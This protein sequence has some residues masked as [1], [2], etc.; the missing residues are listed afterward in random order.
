MN[1]L[2]Q[3]ETVGQA[4]WLDYLKR[5]LITNGE[6]KTLIERDG[7][8]GMTS[9]P[10][11][12]EKAI[13]ESDEYLDAIKA[14]RA[15][16]DHNDMA[17]YEHLAF[18]DTLKWWE[19][20]FGSVKLSDS[21][22]PVIA[23][24]RV[25]APRSDAARVEIDTSFAAMDR[26]REDIRAVLMTASADRE[27]FRLTYPFSPAFVETLVALSSALARDRTALRVM[28]QLLV[29]QRD[30]LEVGQ[31]VP[32]SDLYDALVADDQ[33]MA[34]EL[35]ALWRNAQ[36]VYGD[37]LQRILETHGLTEQQAAGLQDEPEDVAVDLL[38]IAPER[39]QLPC[40]R[41][42]VGNEG[43]V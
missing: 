2:K 7:L 37:I 31:L 22:L 15:Q 19:D 6:L 28:Q 11:I 35:G 14:F 39:A 5:S 26:V 13:A 16:S 30:T 10:S 4:P 34:G 18:A 42:I 21:N 17:I 1:P 43:V 9:N 8:K 40:H 38:C 32:L 27:A 29:D 33:P 36:K 41:L 23:A 3:L 25:L 12:F 20:R 24:R